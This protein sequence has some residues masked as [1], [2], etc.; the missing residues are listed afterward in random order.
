MS[1]QT[2]TICDRKGISKHLLIH[3][4]HIYNIM[5]FQKSFTLIDIGDIIFKHFEGH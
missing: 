4:N 1:V 5:G 2:Q 3:I